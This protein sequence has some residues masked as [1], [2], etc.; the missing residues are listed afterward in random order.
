[1]VSFSLSGTIDRDMQRAEISELCSSGSLPCQRS[2]VSALG[3]A[4]Q[5]CPYPPHE[6]TNFIMLCGRGFD[7]TP[8]GRDSHARLGAVSIDKNN[9]GKQTIL[10][11]KNG[12]RKHRIRGL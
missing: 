11:P 1:M 2:F 4:L 10:G 8:G 3:V 9:Q 12:S 7:S 5:R 6:R